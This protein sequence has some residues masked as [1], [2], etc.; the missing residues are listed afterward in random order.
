MI[1]RH[2]CISSEFLLISIRRLIGILI[3][4]AALSPQGLC[5][6]PMRFQ[7]ITLG[8]NFIISE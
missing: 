4:L 2:A 1:L 3:N 5:V 6:N 7:I 8:N